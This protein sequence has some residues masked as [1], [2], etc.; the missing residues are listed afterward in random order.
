MIRRR[1]GRVVG[2]V[3]PRFRLVFVSGFIWCVCSPLKRLPRRV[4][5]RA[6][7][8]I[9]LDLAPLRDRYGG[10]DG[11]GLIGIGSGGRAKRVMSVG[12]VAVRRIRGGG[13]RG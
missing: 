13:S 5:D 4:D 9:F 7:V 3:S 10:R 12:D 11:G 1:V 8:L 6:G 2:G